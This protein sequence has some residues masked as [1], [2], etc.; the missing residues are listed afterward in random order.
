MKLTR[1]ALLVPVLAIVPA[2]GSSP[3]S[4]APEAAVLEQ[5]ESAGAVIGTS[6][7]TS[8]T[9]GTEA[10]GSSDSKDGTGRGGYV[11]SGS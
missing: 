10:T 2:C 9:F 1:L 11:G 5:R 6:T 3:T 8:T 4:P 7:T